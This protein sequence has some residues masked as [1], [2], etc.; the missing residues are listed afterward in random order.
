[1]TGISSFSPKTRNA[2]SLKQLSSSLPRTVQKAEGVCD[3]DVTL[4]ET[5]VQ[6]HELLRSIRPCAKKENAKF[7]IMAKAIY[8]FIS[9][10]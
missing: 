3:F 7:A 9:T 5:Q 4:L 6:L 10:N 8:D 1:L 2:Y